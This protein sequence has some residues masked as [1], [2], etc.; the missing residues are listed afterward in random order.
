MKEAN[1][2]YKWMTLYLRAGRHSLNY[3]IK[4]RNDLK[5]LFLQGGKV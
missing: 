3:V 1:E 4:I 5:K 2:I